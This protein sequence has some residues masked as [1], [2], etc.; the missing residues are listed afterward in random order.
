[1]GLISLSRAATTP[2]TRLCGAVRARLGNCR[3]AGEEI[4]RTGVCVYVEVVVSRG[5]FTVSLHCLRGASALGCCLYGEGE[6]E[7]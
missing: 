2:T 6:V 3:A 1:M 7:V 4:T 5:V